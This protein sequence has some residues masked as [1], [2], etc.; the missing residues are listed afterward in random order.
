MRITHT[1]AFYVDQTALT[2]ILNRKIDET[3]V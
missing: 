3:I 1:L 2:R